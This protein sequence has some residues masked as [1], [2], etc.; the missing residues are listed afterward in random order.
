MKSPR[1]WRRGTWLAVI[2]GGLLF[3]AFDGYLFISWWI[4]AEVKRQAASARTHYHGDSVE[5]LMALAGDEGRALSDRNLAIWALGQLADAR[6]LPLLRGLQTG[7]PCD[8][9]RRV[10]E[11][12]LAKA[13]KLAEG[14]WNAT[15]WV[16]RRGDLAGG[17]GR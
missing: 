13:I 9:A 7:E 5:A 11:G 16:W 2:L 1:T 6:A 4:G 15:G 3:V 10:C 8:H 14:G 17:I 12:E